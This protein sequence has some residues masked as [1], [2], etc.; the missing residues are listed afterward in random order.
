MKWFKWLIISTI[1]FILL[2]IIKQKIN[3]NISSLINKTNNNNNHFSLRNLQVAND[4]YNEILNNADY[5]YQLY[6]DSKCIEKT[7]T[8]HIPDKNALELYKVFFQSTTDFTQIINSFVTETKNRDE[9]KDKLIT[10]AIYVVLPLIL[11]IVITLSGWGICCSCC[12]YKYCPIVCRKKN[13][14]EP[15]SSTMKKIPIYSVMYAGFYVIIPTT[16]AFN[17]F[18]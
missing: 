2:T 17:Y 3:S 15:Y 16:L 5:I 4:T 9:S 6:V 14:N 18:K 7:A 12:C 10:S 13:T 11:L 1:F 8:T